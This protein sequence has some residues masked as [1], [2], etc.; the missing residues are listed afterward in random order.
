MSAGVGWREEASDEALV[1]A[2]VAG[3]ADAFDRLVDRYDRRVYAICYRYLGDPADAEDAAQETFLALLRR[4]GT[5]TGAASFS[6]WLYRVAT[7]ACHDLVRKRSRRP[8]R[9][10]AD[11]ED[12]GDRVSVDDVLATRELRVEL[13]RALATLEPE[14]RAAV[15]LHDVA[16]VGYAELAQRFGVPIGTVKSRVHRGHARLASALGG[17]RERPTQPS[18]PARPPTAQS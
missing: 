3:D 14:H 10:T 9:A 18:S 7:N 5:F 13:S 15:V 4:A 12:L 11:I 6:T 17:L 16:G 1:A 2:H 8:Q